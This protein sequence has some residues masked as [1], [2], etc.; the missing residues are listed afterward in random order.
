M[1]GEAVSLVDLHASLMLDEDDGRLRKC[2][3]GTMSMPS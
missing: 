2:R 3:G 1:T